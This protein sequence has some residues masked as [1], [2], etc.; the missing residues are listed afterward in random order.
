MEAFNCD[1]SPTARRWELI[2]G[3]EMGL[4]D[5]HRSKVASVHTILS[6]VMRNMYKICTAP[7]GYLPNHACMQF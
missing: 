6:M 7:N 3:L 2:G 4:L 1:E 5:T